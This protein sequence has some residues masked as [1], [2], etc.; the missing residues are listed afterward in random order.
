[1]TDNYNAQWHTITQGNLDPVLLANG[2]QVKQPHGYHPIH[3]P[4]F[5]EHHEH[6]MFFEM[7]KLAKE[8]ASVLNDMSVLDLHMHSI[9]LDD[10]EMADFRA[11]NVDDS[12]ACIAH[13]NWV[14]ARVSGVYHT[15]IRRQKHNENIWLHRPYTFS[16]FGLAHFYEK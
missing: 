6:R 2:Q 12:A 7:Q 3:T 13:L 5:T 15:Y 1:M 11:S 14:H 9:A 16:V 4:N 10:D 8:R